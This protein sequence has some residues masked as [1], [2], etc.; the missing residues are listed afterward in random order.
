MQDKDKAL[1]QK[2]WNLLN[3]GMLLDLCVH[4]EPQTLAIAA[5]DLAA[6]QLGVTLPPEWWELF[7]VQYDDVHAIAVCLSAL[8]THFPTA[9]SE[10]P[11]PLHQEAAQERSTNISVTQATKS[12]VMSAGGLT[13]RDGSDEA[14][15]VTKTRWEPVQNSINAEQPAECD[16]ATSVE[17][18]ENSTSAAEP[19]HRDTTTEAS[20]AATAPPE[21]ISG[22]AVAIAVDQVTKSQVVRS[23]ANVRSEVDERARRNND[24]RSTSRRRDRSRGRDRDRE[25]SRSDG[26]R[27]DSRGRR[28]RRSSSARGQRDARGQRR[29]GRRSRSRSR[30]RSHGRHH[31]SGRR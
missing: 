27:R 30:S 31:R 17:P 2:A 3:D 26:R 16:T 10:W 1:A 14:A 22:Q 13:I 25:R 9:L 11:E 6:A 5:V 29:S 24:S 19:E 18:L 7:G 8:Y 28:R 15:P 23:E 12:T 4:F 20:V 21:R